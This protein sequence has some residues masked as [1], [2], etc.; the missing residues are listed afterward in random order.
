MMIPGLQPAAS[1]LP[2]VSGH[3]LTRVA[4]NW[5]SQTKTT[6]KSQ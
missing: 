1:Y 4:D 3:G 5:V 6:E 2:G